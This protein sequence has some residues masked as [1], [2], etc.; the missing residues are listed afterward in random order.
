MRHLRWRE[1]LQAAPDA[2]RLGLLQQARGQRGGCSQRHG[3]LVEHAQHYGLRFFEAQL[4]LG[5]QQLGE[6]YLLHAYLPAVK[7]NVSHT[8]KIA[9]KRDSSPA[10]SHQATAQ[11]EPWP[12][13]WRSH[14]RA[15]STS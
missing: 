2:E 7:G 1:R 12:R 3:L 13:H 5:A 8:Y 4:G 6:G 14:C 9:R 11:W 15:D 10:N